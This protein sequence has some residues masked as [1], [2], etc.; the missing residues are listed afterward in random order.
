MPATRT[1]S[2]FLVSTA[3]LALSIALIPVWL[4]NQP[5]FR[6]LNGLHTPLTDIMWLA[7]TTLGDGLILA[8]I[9]GAFLL[10][11][12]R[13]TVMGL[14]LMLFASVLVNTVKLLVPTLRPVSLLD[15]VHVLGPLLR[16]GAF[17]SGHTASSMAAALS[18]AYFAKSRAA[19]LGVILVGV[20]ISVSRIFVGAHFPRDIIGGMLCA[21]G[22]FVIFTSLVWPSLEPHIP[23]RPD[24][25]RPAFRILL[26]AEIGAILYALF[27]HA[28]YYAEW[29]VAAWAE[30]GSAA[31]FLAVQSYRCCRGK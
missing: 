27:I 10:A 17:P 26:C 20:L 9:V 19:A 29:S 3:F 28:P 1:R 11:N 12:P 24:F 6:L 18:I 21:V 8:I 5:L 7:L 13:T 15:A 14:V 16:S 22:L 23:D 31:L 2:L 30:A 25:A 4:F